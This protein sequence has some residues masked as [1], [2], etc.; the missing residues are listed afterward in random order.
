VPN[1]LRRVGSKLRA[2]FGQKLRLQIALQ[3]ERYA[4]ARPFAGNVFKQTINYEGSGADFQ[5]DCGEN[6]KRGAFRVAK[7]ASS[8]Q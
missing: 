3:A 8:S 2:Q 4:Q 7:R 1:G 5:T 6:E